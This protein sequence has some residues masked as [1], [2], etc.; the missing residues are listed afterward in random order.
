MFS[1]RHWVGKGLLLL[2]CNS[3]IMGAACCCLRDDWEDFANPNNSIYRNCIC[4][5]CFVQN[6]MYLVWVLLRWCLIR[7]TISIFFPL[8]SWCLIS[9]DCYDQWW[10]IQL[11]VQIC[12]CCV[13]I[14]M[15]VLFFNS[16]T[17]V[18]KMN[19]LYT[20]VFPLRLCIFRLNFLSLRIC[21]GIWI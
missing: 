3:V 1:R 21:R 18:W 13:C 5:Q 11:K 8:K 14:T 2:G 19:L 20:L 9:I 7:K 12:Q 16:K 6:F 17:W 10:L 15:R 4:L